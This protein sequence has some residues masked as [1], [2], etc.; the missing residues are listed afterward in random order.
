MNPTGT[1]VTVAHDLR[2]VETVAPQPSWSEHLTHTNTLV[3]ALPEGHAHALPEGHAVALPR[4]TGCC[5]AASVLRIPGIN[6]LSRSLAVVTQ[7][8]A[9]SPSTCIVPASSRCVVVY[10]W[11]GDIT[12]EDSLI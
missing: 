5:D 1:N 4:R 3:H 10:I 6:V 8:C 2:D 11:Y 12:P 9:A 7:G